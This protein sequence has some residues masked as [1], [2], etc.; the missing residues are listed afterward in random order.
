NLRPAGLEDFADRIAAG[1][2]VVET[3]MALGVGNSG[4][5]DRS[6]C[7]DVPIGQARLSRVLLAIAVHIVELYAAERTERL[8]RAIEAE[9]RGIHQVRAEVGD[10]VK[11]QGVCEAGG[12]RSC[13][14]AYRVG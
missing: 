12:E 3:V 9:L 11:H 14:Q 5:V 13:G 6:R 2:E 10:P 1:N 8:I 7:L 4:D